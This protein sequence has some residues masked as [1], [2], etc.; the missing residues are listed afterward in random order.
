MF[1]GN[2]L[3]SEG[4]FVQVVEERLIAFSPALVRL[5]EE[6]LFVE[7]D[8]VVVLHG[9]KR[10]PC[11]VRLGRLFEVFQS[12]RIVVAHGDD[13]DEIG[14]ELDNRFETEIFQQARILVGEVS[15]AEIG[16]HGA[17]HRRG[18]LHARTA[19]KRG[20]DKHG[21]SVFPCRCL[22]DLRYLIGNLLAILLVQIVTAGDVAERTQH[23]Q[24][25][26]EL[27]HVE[28]RDRNT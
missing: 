12:S 11:G 22:F 27:G 15:H 13:E 5:I 20:H 23:A 10:R 25:V 26:V 4:V 28:V 24:V 7:R 6:Q 21:R 16:E 17:C 18:V 9:R 8:V 14:I 3:H 2:R 19:R 1:A